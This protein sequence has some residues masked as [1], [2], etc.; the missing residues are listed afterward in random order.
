MS[1]SKLSQPT[2]T[3]TPERDNVPVAF[4]VLRIT[5][6]RGCAFMKVKDIQCTTEGLSAFYS[7]S[8]GAK[9]A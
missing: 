3:R 5:T 6:S 1:L 8:G 2:L 4:F 7:A 9:M